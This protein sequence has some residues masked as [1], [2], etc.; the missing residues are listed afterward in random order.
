MHPKGFTSSAE[1]KRTNKHL[2]YQKSSTWGL[3]D[4]EQSAH[5]HCLTFPKASV[6][7][8]EILS[9]V[10]AQ[11]KIIVKLGGKQDPQLFLKDTEVTTDAKKMFIKQ[12]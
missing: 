2:E 6:F 1:N 5:L 4:V 7:L 11:K 9:S 12:H 10:S 8:S 3:S